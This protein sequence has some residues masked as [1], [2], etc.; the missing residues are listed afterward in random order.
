M[1]SSQPMT[2]YEILSLIISGL[3]FITVIITLDLLRRQTREMTA[4][5]NYVAD[6]LKQSVYATP[7]SKAF[8]VDKVFI[9]EPGLRPYFYSGK[10]I[11]EDDPYYDKVI[12]VADLILD[13]F[14]YIVLHPKDVT[15]TFDPKSWERYMKDTF[16]NSPVLRRRLNEAKGKWHSK[17]L[18]AIMTADEAPDKGSPC[19]R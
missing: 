3:G 15:K 19:P 5:S 9:S 12:A 11:S 16:D 14:D 18:A 13:F 8:V 1:V 17:K 10:D 2:L 4:Q 6:S 7:S